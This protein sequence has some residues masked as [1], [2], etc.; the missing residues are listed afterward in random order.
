MIAILTSILIIFLLIFAAF[1]VRSKLRET[2]LPFKKQTSSESDNQ[3]TYKGKP[4]PPGL[5]SDNIYHPSITDSPRPTRAAPAPPP[6]P[7]FNK[8]CMNTYQNPQVT[9]EAHN[10]PQPKSYTPPPQSSV[11]PLL[12]P[13]RHSAP[14]PTYDDAGYVSPTIIKANK[15]T[16][17]FHQQQRSSAPKAFQ[18]SHLMNSDSRAS[19]FSSI[20]AL[21][22]TPK[23]G[24]PVFKPS[25][26]V[27]GTS[28][29]TSSPHTPKHFSYD[30]DSSLMPPYPPQP[31]Q[32]SPCYMNMN[33]FFS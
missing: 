30:H 1:I 16:S 19:S 33:G 14:K 25:P 4:S 23:C 27:G 6:P 7:A 32:T 22:D 24:T 29:N 12:Q 3:G 11:K 13:N 18:D 31:A 5:T 20:K 28:G 15:F 9:Q 17:P 2:S 21:F 8:P 26:L 10:P